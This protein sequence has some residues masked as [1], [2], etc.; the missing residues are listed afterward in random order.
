MD[1][2]TQTTGPQALDFDP[3]ELREKYRQERDK[4]LRRR[5]RGP[6]HRA[7]RHVR[8]LRRGRPLRRAPLPGA[9]HRRGRGRHHRRRLQR[10]A[11]RRP[12]ERGGRH[13]LPHH[14]GGGG[15]RRHL[16]L[17]PLSGR[18][19]RHRVLLLPAAAGGARLHPEGEVL[20]RHRDLRALAAH[21]QPLRPLRHGALPD[22]GA[23]GRLGRGHQA[24]AHPHQPRRRHQG[25][26]RRHGAGHGQP[27]QAARHPGHR[28]FEGHTFHT[29]RWDYDYTGG[30]TTAG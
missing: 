16:V 8:P 6:V 15:L 12:P 17:E 22:P 23:R 18:A 7:R 29:S 13:R 26:L 9:D 21:R 4:R 5:R 19:V 24:L 3:D 30:D 2:G 14:R 27:R 25:A 1:T 10:P 20:L 28:E 11:G